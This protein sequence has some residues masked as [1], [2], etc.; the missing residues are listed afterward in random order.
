MPEWI[1]PSEAGGLLEELLG[2]DPSRLAYQLQIA[3]LALERNRD[4]EALRRLGR[5]YHNFP[6]NHAIAMQYSEA[7]LKSKDPQQ[8]ETASVIL[9][10]Q[11]LYRDED[12]TLYAQYARA[13]N[14]AGDHVR[15]GE[16][17]AE[18][19]YQRGGVREAMEQ[20]EMLTREDDLDY[21]ER[22][23]VSARL[24]ELRIQMGDLGEERRKG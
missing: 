12:P 16:A 5:L 8:A 15:A 24:M 1:F 17:I 11:T 20:L 19:Y 10:Q 13:A 22:S 2:K 18:S 3:N 4:S 14:I 9:R 23:R 6:G 21:Y 7:L